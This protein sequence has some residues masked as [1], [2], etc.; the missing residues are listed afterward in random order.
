MIT[1]K[2]P[3]KFDLEPKHLLSVSYNL[4]QMPPFKDIKVS[5]IKNRSCCC[6]NIRMML[7]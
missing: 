4:G 3:S 2:M 5:I 7:I 6:T 1:T